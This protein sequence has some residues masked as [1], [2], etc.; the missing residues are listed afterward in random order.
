VI[1]RLNQAQIERKELKEVVAVDFQGSK[2]YRR[3]ERAQTHYYFLE[4]SVFAYSGQESVIRQVIERRRKKDGDSNL[5]KQL[6]R[7]GAS[8]AFAA[9][10]VKPI[11][12]E[13]DPKKKAKGS[14]AQKALVLKTFLGY[15]QAL[16]GIILAVNLGDSTEV[17]FTLQARVA[18]LPKAIKPLFSEASI[19]SELWSRFP[20]KSILR[21]VNRINTANLVDTL[22]DLTPPTAKQDIARSIRAALDL[23]LVKDVLPNIGPDWGLCIA[24]GPA[25]S[26]FPH[27]LA[28]LAVRPG[29]GKIAVDRTLINGIRL[30]AGW[31]VFQ[32]NLTLKKLDQNGI[33][34]QYLA[35]DKVF[36]SGLQPAFALKEGYLLL[37]S[38]PEAIGQ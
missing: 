35:N 22:A 7:A 36:P 19:P 15:W 14:D 28:A 21:I 32:Y 9:V 16:E 5:G 37:A 18:D 11:A 2:Y 23:D 26:D 8:S 10:W 1:E 29:P 4:R 20:Q 12:S 27:V 34:I 3:V 31:A 17:R 38:S 25:K 33:E 6:D 13:A 24:S 30:L